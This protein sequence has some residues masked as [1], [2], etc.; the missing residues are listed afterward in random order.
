MSVVHDPRRTPQTCDP[1]PVCPACGGLECFCRPRFFAGQLLT[2]EDLNRLDSYIRGKN[3]LHNRMLHGWGTVNGLEVSCTPCGNTLTVSAGYALSPC[4]EDIVLCDDAIV[5]ICDLINAC[6]DRPEVDCRPYAGREDDCF[7]TEQEWVLAICYDETPTRGVAALRGTS[8]V[9]SC[10]HGN[11]SAAGDCGCQV[12]SDPRGQ[13]GRNRVSRAPLAQCEPTAVCEGHRFR[14]YRAPR[15]DQFTPRD[16]RAVESLYGPLAIRYRACITAIP[17]LTLGALSEN[18]SSRERMAAY[19]RL[20]GVKAGL[21]DFLATRGGYSCE[22]AQ[23]LASTPIPVPTEDNVS[24]FVA[25]YEEARAR[26]NSVRDELRRYCQCSMLLPPPP[27]PEADDCVPLA[28]ITVR[29]DDCT[30]VNIC[31]FGVRQIALSVPAVMYWL[32]AT[33]IMRCLNTYLAALCCGE[34]VDS[35][36]CSQWLRVAMTALGQRLRGGEFTAAVPVDTF[37]AAIAGQPDPEVD[38]RHMT[39]AEIERADFWRASAFDGVIGPLVESIARAPA[40]DREAVG[41]ETLP[42]DPEALREELGR[43]QQIVRR[44]Q[45]Q[46]DDLIDGLD[47]R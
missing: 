12:K 33:P 29:G 19:R 25:V 11:G 8:A 39:Y 14:V 18:S 42:T 1:V 20:C 28:T 46:I 23:W 5:P 24:Q 34:R 40:A 31:N 35:R 22:R 4:G 17:E 37:R 32:S 2:D 27:D 16:T 26:L 13:N 38:L 10:T 36:E 41:R 7:D 6:R 44:Q 15:Q 3:R 43:L 45:E 21:G 9:S 47:S 30:I